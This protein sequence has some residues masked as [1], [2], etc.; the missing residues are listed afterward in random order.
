MSLG[1]AVGQAFLNITPSLDVSAVKGE[2]AKLNG[3]ISN[4]GTAAGKNFSSKFGTAIKV[5]M[6]AAATT[7]I[8]ALSRFTK[9]SITQASDASESI[10]AINVSFGKAAD[11]ILKLSEG[12][13]KRLGV[14]STDFREAAVRFSSFAETVGGG[15]TDRVVGVVNRLTE[16]ATDF[17]SVFNLDVK[18]ALQVFQSGLAGETEPL[19][20]FGIDLSAAAVESY[21]YSR[22]IAENGAELTEAQKVQAR[23]GLLLERTAKTQGDFA[24]TS[25]GLANQQRILSATMEEIQ[26]TVGTALLPIMQELA[27]Y[28]MTNVVPVIQQ[29]AEDFK[30]GKTPVNDLITGIQ[31]MIG[32][33]RD[34][35]Q[36]MTILGG[37]ILGI[38]GAIKLVIG[39]Q[40]AWKAATMA[41]TAVQ[42]AFNLVMSMGPW[43]LV[44]ILIGAVIAGIVYLATQTTFFQDLWAAMVAGI[45][46]GWNGFVNF[47]KVA[48]NAIGGFF[49]NVFKGIGIAFK[50]Y[51]NFWIGLVEGFVNFFIN[52]VNMIIKAVNGIA[53]SVP[54]WVPLIG[55]KKLSLNIPTVSNIKLPRLAEGGLVMPQKGGVQAILAEAGQPEVVYPL[56]RFEKLMGMNQANG[57]PITVNNYAPVG[58]S[59]EEQITKA[60][61]RARTYAGW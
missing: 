43:G 25:D 19:K 60:I 20:R 7:G 10:N 39:I 14:S 9:E 51:V 18:E 56:D 41:F 34:N 40:N 30:N 61:E 57:A 58:M 47:F 11:G 37:S 33:I 15:N 38:V 2:M 4:V 48:I 16:R 54:D 42:A 3:S 6:A 5:G 29:F 46:A 17:A 59:S 26:V 1:R 52:G 23:Y 49:G 22:S 24:N 27:S 35:W 13:A 21:A 53:F 12:T 31:N 28:V 55:G 36:W 8:Y 44:A 45:T 32:F 50:S